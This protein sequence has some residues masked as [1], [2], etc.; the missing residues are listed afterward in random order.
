V[1]YTLQKDGDWI[2][3]E[4]YHRFVQPGFP[5]YELFWQKFVVPLT[6]RPV[7]IH[8]CDDAELAERGFGHKHICIAQLHY[9]VL[10]QLRR[11]L[12]LLKLNPF[13]VDHLVFGMSCLVGAQDVAFELLERFSES[14]SSKYDPWL[15]KRPKGAAS[16]VNGGKEAQK[17]WKKKEKHPLQDIRDYRNN[18]IHGRSLPG[19]VIGD[20]ILIPKLGK[21]RQYFDSRLVTAP[22]A[23][24]PVA[25]F[26]K[27]ANLFAAFFGTTV[28]YFES[29]WQKHLL[30]HL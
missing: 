19:I 29:S 18:L 1:A 26:D 14:K 30:P 2:E 10:A 27:P 7:N 24:L 17:A 5:S 6:N 8:F 9:T 11:C 12:E 22:V 13:N 28:S 4:L 20:T 15:D 21:E 16:H 23:A 3:Q 25:D